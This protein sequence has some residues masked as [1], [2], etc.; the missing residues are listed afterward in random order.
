MT[1]HEGC[2][3]DGHIVPETGLCDYCGQPPED[4]AP[5]QSRPGGDPSG[6]GGPPDVA[7]VDTSSQIMADPRVPDS[8][9]FC[10]GCDQ[11]VGRGYRGQPA[12][13]EGYC[14]S[15]GKRFSYRLTL[16]AGDLVDQRYR[17]RGCINSGGQGYIY[18]A[19]DTHID[20]EAQPDALVVLKGLVNS[21]DPNAVTL[22][23][24]ERRA[25]RDLD[26]PGIVRI[27][28][29]VT[30][31]DPHREGELNGFIVMPYLPGRSLREVIRGDR[32]ELLDEQLTVEGVIGCGLEILAALGYLHGR[33]RLFCD[34]KPANVMLLPRGSGLNRV[35]VVDLGAAIGTDPDTWPAELVSTPPYSGSEPPSVQRDLL[36]TAIT[37]HQ[38]AD[39][40][41]DRPGWRRDEDPEETGS[42]AL[43]SFH[44]AL[45]RGYARDRTWRFE[46]AAEMA[47]QLLG[48]ERELRSLRTGEPDPDP[49][50]PDL[51]A[52][53]GALL[54]AGLGAVPELSRWTEA[55]IP[56]A[57]AAAG[58]GRGKHRRRRTGSEVVAA[59]GAYGV[60]G[61]LGRALPDGRPAP[62][63]A[64]A[65]LPAP[66]VDRDDPAADLLAATSAPDPRRLIGKLADYHLRGVAGA[67]ES[68]ALQLMA[69]RAWIQLGDPSQAADCVARARQLLGT[70]SRR[71]EWQ[72]AWHRGLIALCNGAT[73]AART[74][75]LTVFAALPGELAPKLALGY[76]AEELGRLEAA[77]A[78]YTAVWCRD[79][80][81]A[82]AA[83]G[84]ARLHLSRVDRAGAVRRLDEVPQESRHYDAARV[85]AIKVLSGRLSAAHPSPADFDAAGGRLDL[86]YLDEPA[87][88]R[89]STA[90]RE[91]VLDWYLAGREAPGRPVF[92]L[93]VD[94][95]VIR[96]ELERSFRVIARQARTAD[97]HGVLFDLANAVRPRTWT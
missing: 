15:C 4:A 59:P 40:A 50:P 12:P 19:Q 76:C 75:F 8:Q 70:V 33:D 57:A 78:Y 42:V 5:D 97:D 83:F 92:G 48:V 84:L 64:A 69:C 29:A 95:R 32:A 44:L 39:V 52:P 1:P 89:L 21:A 88:E 6:P 22:A 54:D 13:V 26:H 74:E 28:D 93:P 72:V 37:L 9:R 20:A 62:A 10:S 23:V 49:P 31:P 66:Q 46:S 17:V 47:R 61:V 34:M 30:H 77:E 60:A 7:G 94:E 81:S 90:I 36:A 27:I 79:R 43:R 45:R 65:A 85:A 71:R 91:A 2:E 87:R 18:L 68:P 24:R 25:L 67:A 16:A 41:V 38:L 63:A 14:P 56:A 58:S 80:S 51:F 53:S 86:L 11:P 55:A 96:T 73:A 82:S 3:G 35:K